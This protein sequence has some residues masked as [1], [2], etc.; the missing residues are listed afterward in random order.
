MAAWLC[1]LFGHDWMYEYVAGQKVRSHCFRCGKV[2]EQ[3]R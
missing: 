3:A 2:K 1:R